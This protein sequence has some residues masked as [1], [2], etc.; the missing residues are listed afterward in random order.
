MGDPPPRATL[1]IWLS[2]VE[3]LGLIVKKGDGWR[4]TEKGWRAVNLLPEQ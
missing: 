3:Q 2:E 4:V 1:L